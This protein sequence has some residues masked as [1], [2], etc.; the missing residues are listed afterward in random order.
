MSKPHAPCHSTVSGSSRGHRI[1]RSMYLNSGNSELIRCLRAQGEPR[2]PASSGA[3]AELHPPGRGQA[4]I[5]ATRMGHS[6]RGGDQ[7]TL[8]MGR[9]G[10]GDVGCGV[11]QSEAPALRR[12]GAGRLWACGAVAMRCCG[13]AGLWPCGVRWP[14]PCGAARGGR[15][16]WRAWRGG[17]PSSARGA[18]AIARR[19]GVST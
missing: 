15:P 7:A 6:G 11:R 14:R 18:P 3:A 2:W 9:R 16:R 5:R 12:G 19:A 13:H 4:E 10:A 1:S 8:G 17:R